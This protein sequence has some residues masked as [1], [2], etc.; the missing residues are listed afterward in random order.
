M[1]LYLTFQVELKYFYLHNHQRIVLKLLQLHIQA[2]LI[3]N[4]YT[5][6]IL[7]EDKAFLDYSI[8]QLHL[9]WMEKESLAMTNMDDWTHVV[10]L[11]NVK[12]LILM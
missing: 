11:M 8:H 12:E 6:N 1:F 5:D 10:D 7:K 3:P 4:Y 2:S 9:V